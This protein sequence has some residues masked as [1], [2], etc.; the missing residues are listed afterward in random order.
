[1]QAKP[2][3]GRPEC[4]DFKDECDCNNPPPFCNDSCRSF[5]PIGDRYVDGVEDPAWKYLNKTLCSKG[6]DELECPKRFKCN[7]T[8]NISID[9]LQ[10]CDG[11]QDC[12]DRS[13]EINCTEKENKAIF[14]FDIDMIAEPGIKAAFWIM[15]LFVLFG[16]A[17]VVDT[18]RF[19]KKQRV[20]D[21]TIFQRVIILNIKSLIL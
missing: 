17:C 19:L 11:K 18:A 16:N 15:R 20:L 13:D 1:M 6:F 3:D 5:F 21:F 4:K 12:D 14:S 2:C 8:G 10:V 7:A 9:V